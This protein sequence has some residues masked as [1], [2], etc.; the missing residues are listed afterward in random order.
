M[1]VRIRIIPTSN[2]PQG[3]LNFA[4]GAY[5]QRFNDYAHVELTE[6]ILDLEEFPY[7]ITASR[8]QYLAD[9]LL[10]AGSRQRENGIAVVLTSADI[11]T[12]GTNYIFGLASHGSALVSSA[13]INPAFW[14][15]IPDIFQYTSNGRPFFERQYTKVL[16]HELGHAFGMLH[17]SNWDCAMHYSNSPIELYRKGED[18]CGTCWRK[19]LAGIQKLV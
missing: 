15:D 2:F 11:Y 4:R 10:Q 9:A 18:Y 16:I 8:E 19:F 6:K 14:A 1:K 5:I 3:E 12:E 13:R 7:R 17:C